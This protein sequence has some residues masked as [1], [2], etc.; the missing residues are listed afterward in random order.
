VDFNKRFRWLVDQSGKTQKEIAEA[1]G[2]SRGAINNYY[3]TDRTPKAEELYTLAKYFG[4]SMEYLLGLAAPEEQMLHSIDT[5]T[6]LHERA[7]VTFGSAVTAL[8]DLRET[9]AR[10]DAQTDA[11]RAEV[12][13]AQ[14][15]LYTL[16]QRILGE[17][18]D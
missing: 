1:T 11:L 18:G 16:E 6:A 7:G 2:I 4:V 10:L 14:S 13:L 9:L 15:K 12:L 5:A 3:K 8:A 17:K